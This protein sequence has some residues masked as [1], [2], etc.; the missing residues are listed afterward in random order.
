MKKDIHSLDDL[1]D[2]PS[3]KNWVYQSNARDVEFWNHWLEVYPEKR[4]MAEKAA[5]VVKG[6]FFNK[7]NVPEEEI[8]AHWI[9]LET[10]LNRNTPYYYRLFEKKYA[11]AATLALVLLSTLSIWLVF[12]EPWVVYTT[13]FG[14]IRNIVLPDSSKVTLNANSTLSFRHASLLGSSERR[15]YLEGEAYFE[16]LK[17]HNPHPAKFIVVTE[18]AEVE[19][20]GTQF[21]VNSRRGKTRVVLNSGKVKFNVS[22]H[23]KATLEP[24]DMVEYSDDQEL[25]LQKVDPEIHNSWVKQQLIFDDTSLQELAEILEDNYGLKVI[26]NNEDLNNKRITGEISAKSA[27]VILTAISKL[28][29]IKVSRSG[30]TVYLS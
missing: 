15:I 4:K 10:K 22:D 14:E 11:I 18:N 21:N 16:V 9:A 6:V 30:N 8:E 3:F 25:T 27:T 7:P 28:F 23:Q 1:V 17:K 24:G 20:L 26:I 2:N 5:M 13:A 29:K 12:H 19:V